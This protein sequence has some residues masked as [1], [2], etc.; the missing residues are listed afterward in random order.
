MK[1]LLIKL[2]LGLLI[3]PCMLLGFV[4]AIIISGIVAGHGLARDFANWVIR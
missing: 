4:G 1:F 2:P 3:A